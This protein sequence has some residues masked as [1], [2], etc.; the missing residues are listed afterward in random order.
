MTSTNRFINRL[1]LLIVGVAA[2]LAAALL[3]APLIPALEAPLRAAL[4]SPLAQ[5]WTTALATVQTGAPWVILGAMVVLIV[6]CVAWIATR[7]RGRIA[8]AFSADGLAIDDTV[9]AGALRRHLADDPDV[10]AVA[11]QA[12]R[13]TGGAVLVRV[14]TRSRADLP[15]LLD[16]LRAAV[17]SADLTIGTAVPLVIHLTTGVRTLASGSRTTK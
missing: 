17:A 5:Q 2:L 14:E 3:A 7:G 8:D 6:L 1:L 12:F 15:A 11:A 10:L 16:D 13:R 4:D 9:V